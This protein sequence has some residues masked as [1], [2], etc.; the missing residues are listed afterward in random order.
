MPRRQDER[1]LNLSK[2]HPK[3]CTCQDC[4]DKFLKKKEIKA[5]VEAGVKLRG[6]DRVKRHPA[7][8]ECAS[9]RLLKSVNPIDPGSSGEAGS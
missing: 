9:C 3:A 8:C 6:K 7:G 2:K 5:R 4:T 1:W